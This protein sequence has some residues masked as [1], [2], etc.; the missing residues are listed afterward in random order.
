M[1]NELLNE[2][3]AA[4]LPIPEDAAGLFIK[5]YQ[6]LKEWNDKFNITAITD[7]REVV[8]KHFIDSVYG[9]KYIKSGSKCVDIGAGGGFPSVPLR[10]IRPDLR[11]TAV[12]SVNKKVIFLREVIK[13]L[14]LSGLEAVNARAEDL[15]APN[16]SRETFDIAVSRAVARLNT[17]CEYSLPLVRVGGLFIAYKADAAIEI[18][19]AKRAILLLGGSIKDVID[20]ELCGNRRTLVIIEKV[21]ATDKKY[22]RG[23]GRERSLPL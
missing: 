7:F 5:Y 4:S 23:K 12:D 9:A 14:E 16:V 18:A 19:E 8:Q 22:P 20:Y 3:N 17:L 2:F 10:I 21:K 11:I 15:A 13:S 1:K 6:L